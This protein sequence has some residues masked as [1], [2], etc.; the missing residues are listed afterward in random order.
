L[1]RCAAAILSQRPQV[2]TA[3]VVKLRRVRSSQLE[4][5][6]HFLSKLLHG[7][8]VNELESKLNRSTAEKCEELL[9]PTICCS[10]QG[11]EGEEASAGAKGHFQLFCPQL[12]F[13]PE[14]ELEISSAVLGADVTFAPGETGSFRAA[15]TFPAARSEYLR[16]LLL[17]V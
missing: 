7:F 14:S 11:R 16:E 1:S 13:L 3:I 2:F 15:L 8:A 4:H 17:C 12:S 5:T 10:S 6:S 9:I